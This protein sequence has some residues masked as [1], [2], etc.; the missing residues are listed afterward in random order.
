MKKVSLVLAL[1]LLFSFV[2]VP[3]SKA[4]YMTLEQEMEIAKRR[5]R[6]SKASLENEK[7]KASVLKGTYADNRVYL[8]EV[9]KEIQSVYMNLERTNAEINDTENSIIETRNKLSKIGEEIDE[10]RER[11]NGLLKFINEISGKRFIDFIFS[12]T[13]FSDLTTRNNAINKL[14]DAVVVEMNK[15][16]EE[17][18]GQIQN[19]QNLENKEIRLRELKEKQEKEKESLEELKSKQVAIQ[20]TIAFEIEVSEEKKKQYLKAL[21]DADAKVESIFKA[22]EERNRQLQMKGEFMWPLSTRVTSVYGMRYHPIFKTNRMHTGIDMPEK[23]GAP[24]Y[25]AADGIVE[26]CAWLGGYGNCVIVNHGMNEKYGKAFSTLYGH[27]SKYGPKKGENVKKGQVV[28]YIGSTG[29]STGP[30]LHFEI[31]VNGKHD[32]P[33]K[34]LPIR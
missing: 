20:N 23:M 11:V 29:W 25:C 15:L 1:L 5:Q 24:I 33:Q 9:N 34:Y 14:L 22:I 27:M 16:R 12:A 19:Q 31:R 26:Y 10:N 4:S 18:A 8:E 6:E 3:V 7:K 30:H 13:D 28:G 2:A 21:N 32:N 17:S